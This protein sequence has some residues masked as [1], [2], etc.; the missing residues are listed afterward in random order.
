MTGG[1]IGASTSSSSSSMARGFAAFLRLSSR[2][3]LFA[4]SLVMNRGSEGSLGNSGK[5]NLNAGSE[6]SPGTRS[7]TFAIATFA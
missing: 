6:D 5:L 4:A 1:L 2:A 7:R 3:S